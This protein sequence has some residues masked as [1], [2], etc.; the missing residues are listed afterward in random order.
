MEKREFHMNK[1][2]KKYKEIILYL[3]FGVLTTLVN[4]ITYVLGTRVLVLDVYISNIL[5]WILSVW[6]AYLTN[7]KYVFNS[8]AKTMMAKAKETIAFYGYRVFTLL[9]DMALM[10]IMIDALKIDDMISKIIVNIVV[11]ILNYF[12]SKF[13]IFKKIIKD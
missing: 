12:S 1:T 13:L 9:I 10:Y 4:I 7:R 8:K 6:F 2:I 5:A 11:M 3:I